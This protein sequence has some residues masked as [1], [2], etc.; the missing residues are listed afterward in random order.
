MSNKKF[1]SATLVVIISGVFIFPYIIKLI[2]WILLLV[3]KN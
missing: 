3:F 1:L 2:S